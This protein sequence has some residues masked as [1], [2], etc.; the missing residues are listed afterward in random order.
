MMLD[1]GCLRI[2]WISKI[3]NVVLSWGHDVTLP[4]F[5]DWWGP[6]LKK[7]FN[8]ISW[9]ACVDFEEAPGYAYHTNSYGVASLGFILF[10]WCWNEF[11][12]KWSNAGYWVPAAYLGLGRSNEESL[13]S[14]NFVREHD[15][16]ILWLM[17][18]KSYKAIQQ[19]LV[20]C[21]RWFWRETR[22]LRQS[23]F[24]QRARC[25]ARPIQWVAV[26]PILWVACVEM[27]IKA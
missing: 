7:P 12:H 26:R 13:K 16:P 10:G 25:K 14:P 27:R 24:N 4:L 23:N 21:M 17:R 20:S 3:V 19:N 6:N 8:K 5:S 2:S 1:S 15:C 9:V 11:P 22:Q 18:T